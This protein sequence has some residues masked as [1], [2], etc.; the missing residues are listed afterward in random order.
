MPKTRFGICDAMWSHTHISSSQYSLISAPD[1][2]GRKCMYQTVAKALLSSSIFSNQVY[3][4]Q[5]TFTL[6]CSSWP[7]SQ[8]FVL[9]CYSDLNLTICLIIEFEKN[10]DSL[11]R[12]SLLDPVRKIKATKVQRTFSV[13]SQQKK[14]ERKL[15]LELLYGQFN[16]ILFC[17]WTR[18]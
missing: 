6:P 15:S 2:P 14:N 18:L 1:P 8:C 9:Q 5:S 3:R 16:L 7:S 4:V 11:F 17:P 10:Q 12:N 13:S